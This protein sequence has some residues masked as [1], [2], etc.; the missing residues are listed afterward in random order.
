MNAD[1]EGFGK[2][3]RDMGGE[4]ERDGW[5]SVS[6][7]FSWV[8]FGSIVIYTRNSL[9]SSQHQKA[10]HSQYDIESFILCLVDL[11]LTNFLLLSA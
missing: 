6:K 1:G 5:A 3:E 10:K 2:R 7:S 8:S 11:S 9:I 4:R